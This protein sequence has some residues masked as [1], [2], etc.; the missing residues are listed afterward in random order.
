MADLERTRR[1][2]HLQRKKIKK[3]VDNRNIGWYY[4]RALERAQELRSLKTEQETSI[5]KTK[6]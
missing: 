3:D 1:C 2:K 6:I 5:Q 4:I